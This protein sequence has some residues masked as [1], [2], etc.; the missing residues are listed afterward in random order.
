MEGKPS[1]I[2]GAVAGPGRHTNRWMYE[3]Q[4]I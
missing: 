2:S 1:E 4:V 3:E